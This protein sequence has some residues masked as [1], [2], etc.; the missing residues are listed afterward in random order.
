MEIHGR[1]IKFKRTVLATC[2]VADLSPGGDINKFDELLLSK[3][4][5]ITQRAAAGFMAALSK[6]YE[7]AQAF[8][9]LKYKPRPLTVDEALC[10]DN[11]AF[12]DL[13]TEALAAW[14][15]EKPTVETEP[16]KTKG[17]NAE[18]DGESN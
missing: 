15:V 17:K 16:A 13:F 14:G 10:L 5:A 3:Q 12:S 7:M 18:G 11:D 6:G 4:Y 2:E 1:E 9:D 8:E